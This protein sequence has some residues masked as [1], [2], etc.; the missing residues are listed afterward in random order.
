[1]SVVEM[2]KLTM[3]QRVD[4]CQAFLDLDDL[5]REG[6]VEGFGFINRNKCR[7]FLSR[8]RRQG[9]VPGQGSFAIGKAFLEY[10]GGKFTDGLDPETGTASAA[11][12]QRDAKT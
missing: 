10:V 9:Y 4:S 11:K 1:M 12:T 8:A 3:Q 6:L 7:Q 5:Q 2:H